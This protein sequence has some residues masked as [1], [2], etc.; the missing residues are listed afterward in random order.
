MKPLSAIW[1]TQ[2]TMTSSTWLPSRPARR[3]ASLMTRPPRSSMGTS[4]RLPPI[5]P[6]AVL[7][8]AD[9]DDFFCKHGCPLFLVVTLAAR[10]FR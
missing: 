5:A 3:T 4:F 1:P 7:N 2:P 9:D 8:S 10:R 6:I